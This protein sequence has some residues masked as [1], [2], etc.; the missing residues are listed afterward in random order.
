VREEEDKEEGWDEKDNEVDEVDNGSVG[1]ALEWWVGS[2]GGR[3]DVEASVEE[4]WEVVAVRRGIP[5]AEAEL[6]DTF[7]S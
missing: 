6:S 2:M 4:T 1:R 3:S 7:S 5:A